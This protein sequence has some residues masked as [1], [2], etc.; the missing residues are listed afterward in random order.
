MGFL[1]KL[2]GIFADQ[3][4]GYQS[5]KTAKRILRPL[6]HALVGKN[7][8]HLAMEIIAKDQHKQGKIMKTIVEVGGA[9]G[10][11]TFAYLKKFPAARVYFF[12]PQT[13]SFL[14]ARKK[15][16]RFGERVLFFKIGL[17][18]RASE[19]RLNLHPNPDRSSLTMEQ[20][21]HIGQETIQLERLDAIAKQENIG[22][23]DFMKIDVEG[24]QQEVIAG[25]QMMLRQTDY[26][27][28]EIWPTQNGDYS[29]DYL[30]TLSELDALGFR[31]MTV[32][33]GYDFLMKRVEK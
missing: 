3:F 30:K 20:K 27:L 17:F 19:G 26:L 6:K 16:K 7:G 13:S 2:Y 21:I 22:R 14:A 4:F 32:L 8:I 9:D 5:V 12:E 10:E 23:I 15:L 28:I 24:V 29:S 25:A 31:L 11:F 18:S 1:D 33:E